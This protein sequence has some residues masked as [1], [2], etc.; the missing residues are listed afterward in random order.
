MAYGNRRPRPCGYSY[1]VVVDNF[2]S[3]TVS[4]IRPRSADYVGDGI[5]DEYARSEWSSVFNIGTTSGEELISNT[6]YLRRKKI[7]AGKAYYA[8]HWYVIDKEQHP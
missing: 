3:L 8:G 4:K 2:K 1:N 7:G 5:E 6:S